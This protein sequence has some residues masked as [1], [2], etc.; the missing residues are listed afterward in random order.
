MASVETNFPAREKLASESHAIA[1][2]LRDCAAVDEHAVALLD[3]AAISQPVDD[4]LLRS[5]AARDIRI[6]AEKVITLLRAMDHKGLLAKQGLVSRL[7]GA[8]LEARLRFELAGQTVEQAMRAMRQAAYNGQHI[9]ALLKEA[10]IQLT[11]EQERLEAL[12][13]AAKLLL[14]ER[15]V[16]SD[17]H[18][19]ARFERR[20]SNIMAL[21]AA[22]ILAERQ[23]VL[24]RDVLVGLLDRVTDVET[25]I[26]PLWQR[27]MLALAHAA[28]GPQQREAALQFGRTHDTALVK[29]AEVECA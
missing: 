3:S 5:A 15:A 27:Q 19:V 1:Q 9:A 18:A 8:D 23:I 21:H 29:L 22:N 11:E 25:V 7:T 6:Q 12:I 16:Q 28:A 14:A 20:L 13:P 10:R 17:A 26:M 4:D 24:A 2:L